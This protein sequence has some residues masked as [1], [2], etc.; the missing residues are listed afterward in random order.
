MIDWKHL[1]AEAARLEAELVG[2]LASIER[3]GGDAD[4]YANFYGALETALESIGDAR[5]LAQKAAE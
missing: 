2:F 3:P 1:A 5:A 4:A